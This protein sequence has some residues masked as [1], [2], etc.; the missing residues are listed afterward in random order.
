MI[1]WGDGSPLRQLI[2]SEDLARLIIW[3]L[4]NW[5][6]DKPF[7]AVNPKEHSVLEIATI[8]CKEM[9]ISSEK[10]ILDLNKPTGQFKKTASTDA[11]DDFKFMDL[12]TG[13]EKTVTWFNKNYPNIR[14]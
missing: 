12:S 9:G 2:Y 8:I 7:M 1:L 5:N 11:P 3:A 4:E 14:S 13:I 10:L 6:L